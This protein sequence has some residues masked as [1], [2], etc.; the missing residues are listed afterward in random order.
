MLPWLQ[1]EKGRQAARLCNGADSHPLSVIDHRTVSPASTENAAPLIHS[2]WKHVKHSPADCAA[3]HRRAEQHNT[4]TPRHAELML[5]PALCTP[6]RLR[7]LSPCALMAGGSW[8][9]PSSVC[10]AAAH[11]PVHEG[12]CERAP[13]PLR[14][15]SQRPPLV[16]FTQEACA[17]G[18]APAPPAQV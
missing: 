4:S 1:G 12:R 15:R 6:T 16:L 2:N 7:P 10:S 17:P 3:L 9:T 14:A 8:F 5:Q 18:G 13:H 11:I